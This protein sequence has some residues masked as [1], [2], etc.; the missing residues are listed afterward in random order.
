PLLEGRLA[1]GEVEAATAV[2]DVD[3]HTALLGR[4]RGRQE[5]P[6]LDRVVPGPAVRVGQD[7]AGAEQVEQVGQVARGRPDVAHDAGAPAGH[8]RGPDR[9]AKGLEAVLSH[10]VVGD[11]DLDAQDGV[12]VLGDD[13]GAPVD[14][15]VVD[16]E[17]LARGE[18]AG[19]ADRGD[20]HE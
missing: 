15:R 16:V 3:D 5:P 8:L 11:A 2:P 18:A 7:V 20:V 19:E 12:G 14:V 6:V 4:Q 10:D 9:A 17:H 13:L 1:D